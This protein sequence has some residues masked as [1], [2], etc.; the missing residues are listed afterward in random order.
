VPEMA[1]A[2]PGLTETENSGLAV[3][4]SKSIVNA[5]VIMFISITSFQI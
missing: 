4:A 1:P 5:E 3:W 2:F